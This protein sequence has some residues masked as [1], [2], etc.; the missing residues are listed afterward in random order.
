MNI[1]LI[2]FSATYTTRKVVRT[3][4][5]RMGEIVAEHDITQT[6][7]D[8]DMEI[9]AKNLAIVGMPVYAG[10]IPAKAAEAL[11][12]FKG[13]KTPV[14]VVCVYGNRDYD[15]ALLELKDITESNG[16]KVIAAGAF[17]AQHS[18]FPKV[19]ADRP[20]EKDIQLMQVF[21]DKSAELYHS[22][23]NTDLFSDILVKGNKPYKIPGNVPLKPKGNRHC[24][25]CGTCV[26]LCP[27]QAIDEA[28]PRKTNKEKCISCGRCIVICPQKAR[29]FRGLLYKIVSRKFTKANSTCKEPEMA[30]AMLQKTID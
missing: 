27:T 14:I 6:V 12:R 13:N 1:H 2:Y 30:Y 5:K 11:S 16:F 7:P 10:R 8:A 24:N 4:A 20:D 19:G 21:A 22:A 28:A 3:I 25:E 18:I 17:V 23:A 26:K 29:A 15:D 9:D